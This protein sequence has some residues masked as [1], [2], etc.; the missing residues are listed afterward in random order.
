LPRVARVV[1]LVAVVYTKKERLKERRAQRLRRDDLR[2]WVS[3]TEL[4]E[5]V[6]VN[7]YELVHVDFDLILLEL[8]V[9]TP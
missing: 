7:S 5:M 8:A 3:F 1:S 9:S 6:E 4:V 2:S